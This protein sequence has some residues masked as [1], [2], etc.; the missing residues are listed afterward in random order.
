MTKLLTLVLFLIGAGGPLLACGVTGP[1]CETPLGSYRISLPETPPTDDGY[2]ALLFFHGAGGS[3]A[4]TLSNS[5]MV[6][7]FTSAG[8]AVI[9][10]DGLR[11]EGS[12]FGPGWSFHPERPAQRDEAAFTDEVIRNAAEHHGVDPERIL[13]S[14]FS[15][16]G[17]LTWYL[18]C[19]KPDL[20]AAYAPV[21]G[22]F[23][24]PHPVEGSCAGPV[25][26]LHTHG[27]RDR[28]VPLEGRPLGDGRIYQG[29]VFH[30]LMLL[31]Q[32]NGCNEMRADDFVTDGPFWRRKWTNCTPG[33][34]LELALH[35]GGHSVPSGW[36]EMAIKWFRDIEMIAE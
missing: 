27:W 3:G 9:A 11:R 36:S 15:I 19:A 35:T 14:G 1:A 8:F 10:P 30:S 23:W 28:V 32:Q 21:A 25:R 34:A 20:A 2:P 26:M 4:R 13:M 17:S 22:A 18:A 33:T 12:R 31:R 7:A 24:R 5:A 29:D 6:S 16:G